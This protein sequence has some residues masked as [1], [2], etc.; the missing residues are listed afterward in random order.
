M[1]GQPFELHNL[2]FLN[3][4]VVRDSG[5]KA[6]VRGE[7]I[8]SV[9]LHLIAEGPN[10]DQAMWVAGPYGGRN[11]VSVYSCHDTSFH[12]ALRQPSR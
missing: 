9:M 7:T 5:V 3:Q 6:V 11:G 10:A 8:G 12:C 1:Q 4:V 2:L